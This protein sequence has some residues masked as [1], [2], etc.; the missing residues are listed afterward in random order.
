MANHHMV[1]MLQDAENSLG[2]S[3][4]FLK[5][6]QKRCQDIGI[7]GLSEE[8]DSAY[9]VIEEFKDKVAAKCAY[10]EETVR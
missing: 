4:A 9:A 6:A 7:A 8:M 5:A 10:L 2:T 1:E 3:L